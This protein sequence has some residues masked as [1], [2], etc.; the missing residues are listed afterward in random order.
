MDPTLSMNAQSRSW[1][2]K[3]LK[4]TEGILSDVSK[5]NQSQIHSL[6]THTLPI[7]MTVILM[8]FYTNKETIL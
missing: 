2:L 1:W 6:C 3:K 5:I 7:K 4:W 8:L